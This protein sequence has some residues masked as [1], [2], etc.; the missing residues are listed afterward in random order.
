MK[1]LRTELLSFLNSLDG[2]DL[3]NLADGNLSEEEAVD[4]YLSYS[5]D[6]IIEHEGRKYKE[7]PDD[8]TM[9]DPCRKCCFYRKDEGCVHSIDTGSVSY[10]FTKG[11]HFELV[12]ETNQKE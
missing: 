8:G 3:R 4:G 7:V 2:D 11:C 12:T 1:D 9:K 6:G 10:C 5:E